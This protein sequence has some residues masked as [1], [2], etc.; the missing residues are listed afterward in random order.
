MA[1]KQTGTLE[2]RGKMA[3]ARFLERRGYE[4]L[5]RNWS[6]PEGEADI[7]AKDE[8]AVVFVDVKTKKSAIGGFPSK[9]ISEKVRDSFERVALSYLANYDAVDY[10]VR[11][12]IIS[13]VVI[14]NDKAMIRHCI[15]ALGE[16]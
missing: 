4:I 7:I 8:K 10:S 12:D 5:E 1:K 6:C 16:A 11:F 2:A 3:A 13:L 15:N 9:V 14:D